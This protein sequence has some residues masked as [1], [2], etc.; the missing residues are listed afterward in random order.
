MNVSSWFIVL[1][2]LWMCVGC[3]ITP[4]PTP[5]PVPTPVP[6]PT[7]ILPKPTG[8]MSTTVMNRLAP[9]D[10]PACPGA[11]DLEQPIEFAWAGIEDVR[12]STPSSNW[13]FYR[14]NESQ[15]ILEAFYK[16]WMPEDQYRWVQTYWEERANATLGVFY[17][18]TSTY[19]VPN[20]WLYL[21]FLQDSSAKQTSYLAVAWWEVPK[22]C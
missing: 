22:S 9:S 17:Y 6:S 13:I 16:Y 4:T 8:V 11:Q 2:A 10:V 15:A 5:S 12:Q 3:A 7:I 14:C 1:I 20:R 21:W 18:N 19:G